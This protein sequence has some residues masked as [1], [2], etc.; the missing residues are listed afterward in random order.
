V[1][2]LTFHSKHGTASHTVQ[3]HAR[4][5]GLQLT[6]ASVRVRTELERI[7]SRARQGTEATGRGQPEGDEL[8]KRLNGMSLDQLSAHVK[9]QM[10]LLQSAQDGL[11]SQ[12]A[13]GPHKASVKV[14]KFVREFDRF[15]NAYSG[16][17]SIVTLVDAQYGSVASATLSLLFAVGQ[18]H[19]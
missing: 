5:Y 6:N 9:A 15:L 18:F 3:E 4:Q 10:S 16:I 8:L 2:L 19:K 1:H 12:R 13:K 17:V 11:Q 14:Q 7:V